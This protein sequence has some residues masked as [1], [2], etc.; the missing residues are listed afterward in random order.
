MVFSWCP[1][2]T[3][4][5][6]RNT[7]RLFRSIVDRNNG[8]LLAQS[9]LNLPHP[10]PDPRFYMRFTRDPV[11]YGAMRDFFDIRDPWNLER[12]GSARYTEML[13][14]PG[15][16][17]MCAKWTCKPPEWLPIEH[18]LCSQ[19]CRIQ[20]F[21]EDVRFLLPQR[22]YLPPRH[23]RI[24][25]YIVPWLSTV[26]NTKRRRDEGNHGFLIRD[27]MAA[28][29]EYHDEVTAAPPE[30]RKQREQ[31]LFEKYSYRRRRTNVLSSWQIYMDDWMRDLAKDG[32]RLEA[33]NNS[34]LRKIARKHEIPYSDLKRRAST[35]PSVRRRKAAQQRLTTAAI[36][37]A[38]LLVNAK[39][40]RRLC[41]HCGVSIPTHVL[42]TH[43]A[44]RHPEA[45]PH[46]RLNPASGNAEYRCGLC[47]VPPVRWY[48]ANS[49]R[50]HHYH[51]FVPSL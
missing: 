22:H 41:D 4:F 43:V 5:T 29:K 30:E 2:I 6:V 24:D 38:G 46:R 10:P 45:L 15:R 51:Q 27:L 40:K 13:F 9:P 7:C 49:L 23:L 37:K 11:K 1:P 34:R 50:A 32:K 21:H 17:H 47:D 3:L 20:F 48:T 28:R 8:A 36:H 25:R 35:Q 16:C 18:R 39:T 42:D 14:K 12:Y 31:A 26:T 44:Q 19:R 33:D